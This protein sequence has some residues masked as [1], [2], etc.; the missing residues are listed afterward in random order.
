MNILKL[1]GHVKPLFSTD[2]SKSEIQLKE[3]IAKSSF[4]VFG[5]A[6]SIGQAVTKKNFK[7]TSSKLHVAD[8]SDNNMV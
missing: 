1:I 4:L 8:I 5:G 7:R 3:V 6:G 2:I